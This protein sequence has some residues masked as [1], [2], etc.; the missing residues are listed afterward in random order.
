MVQRSCWGHCTAA[1]GTEA[2]MQRGGTRRVQHIAGSAANLH[3]GRYTD[4]RP[5]AWHRGRRRGTD[6]EIRQR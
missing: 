6:L 2:C 1:G 4:V 3:R 5:M